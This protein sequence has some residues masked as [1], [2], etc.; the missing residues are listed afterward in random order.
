MQHPNKIVKIIGVLLFLLLFLMSVTMTTQAADPITLLNI[1]K[2]ENPDYTRIIFKLSRLPKFSH[3]DSGERIDLLLSNVQQSPKLH[4]LP[5]GENIVNI[6]LVEQ[7]QGLM[8]SILLRHLPKQV[9]TTSK[10]DSPW[11]IIDVYWDINAPTRPAVAFKNRTLRGSLLMF[12][13]ISTLPL[14]RRWLLKFL[15]CRHVKPAKG[16]RDFSRNPPGKIIG[17]NSS[18]TTGLIGN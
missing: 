11:V 18:V 1:Q 16:R 13:G 7:P 10:P 8:V 6:R 9:I 12:I 17:I 4:N 5:E 3:E 15:I 14:D 2:Q